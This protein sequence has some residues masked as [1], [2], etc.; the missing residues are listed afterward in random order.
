MRYWTEYLTF[1]RGFSHNADGTALKFFPF[2]MLD[3][4]LLVPD[5]HIDCELPQA[6]K[7]QFITST[8]P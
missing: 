8:F 2:S 6:G 7:E 5:S 3:C 4:K 1:T